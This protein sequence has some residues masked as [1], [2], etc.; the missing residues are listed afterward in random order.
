MQ[1]A[2]PLPFDGKAFVRTLTTSPGV[3]RHF[4]AAGEL[5]YVG[6]AGNLKKRVGSYFLKPRMEPRIAAMVAQIARVEITVTRT[7]GEALLLESQLI[8]SLKPR[9]NILLRDDKSY[10]YIYL[11]TG[12]DYPRLAFHRGAKNLPGRYFGPYPSV[13]AVRESLNLMQKL[14]KVRQCEDSYFR[15]R[16]RPCLLYQIGR[17]SAPC[18][19]LISVE[20]YRNDVRHAEMF[21]EGRSNAVIDELAEAMEQ[22]SKALQFERAAKL[23]DQVAALRQLQAQNHV[24]GASADMDVIACRIEAGMAC[25]SVLFFRNGISL[26][27]RDFFP[28]LPLDAEPADVLAQFIAQYYLDRPVPRELILGEALADQAILAE[29]LGQY[30]G[31]EVE[32]KSSVR[33]ER[34]QFLQMAERNAQAS[35]TARLASRQTL[36]TRFDDL[37]KVLGLDESPR[38]IECFDISHTLGELT[39]AS[40]VVFGPEGPEKSHYRRFNITGITPGDDYAAMHQALTRRFRKLA[41]GEGARPDVLLIDGGGGQVAQALEVLKE[42]GVDGIEVVGVAKGPGRRAGEETLVLADSGR[43]LHPGSSSPALHLVAAVRDEA[44]RFAISGHRKRREK[45]REHSVLEDVPGIGARRRTAL[46][47]AFGGMQGL[48]RAGVEELM[49]VKGIDRGLAERIYASLHG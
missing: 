5:L 31:R 18:V 23:R 2:Q 14:F 28:R 48:E 42:L 4:D 8:K 33:G 7:E 36:G 49:Q 9:Y 16:T 43:E 25:V 32:L 44:H 30:A 39:V 27:T 15:N 10:P 47:K 46:L 37:Q 45:A 29:L 1:S 20:D 26:G 11:S 17:C 41:E 24:Q 22:A 6:K 13:Y 38:R 34:A 35:L 3:Y 12:E 40:C 19:G 21:L